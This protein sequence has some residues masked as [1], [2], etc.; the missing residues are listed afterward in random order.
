MTKNE[1]PLTEEQLAQY[2]S[3]NV[4][5]DATVEGFHINRL[6]ATIEEL[7]RE[8]DA[9][10]AIRWTPT[11]DNHHNAWLC[12]HCNVGSESPQALT[13]R[14][15]LAEAEVS[16]LRDAVNDI[17]HSEPIPTALAALLW[18][19]NIAK[20]ALSPPGGTDK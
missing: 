18:C 7:Q 14:A 16:R 10:L 4:S 1:K 9:A 19:Q 3:A 17:A 20:A 15:S 8:R 6:L 12:P 2:K 5:S 11:G 13:K